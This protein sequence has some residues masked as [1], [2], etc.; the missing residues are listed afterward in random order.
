M[1]LR[2]E[3]IRQMNRR[4]VPPSDLPQL[5]SYVLTVSTKGSAFFPLCI[6]GPSLLGSSLGTRARTPLS[7]AWHIGPP[8]FREL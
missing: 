5:L 3:L 7:L 2:L 6:L 8:V 4:T 1:S